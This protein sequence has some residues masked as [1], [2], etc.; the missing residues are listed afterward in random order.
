MFTKH[1]YILAFIGMF[2]LLIISKHNF[3]N[4]L[5]NSINCE[6]NIFFRDPNGSNPPSSHSDNGTP[7]WDTYDAIN[8]IYLELGTYIYTNSAN[9]SIWAHILFCITVHGSRLDYFNSQYLSL[10]FTYPLRILFSDTQR[11]LC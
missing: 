5:Y 11:V 1:H 3:L 7:F 4:F 10:I 2:M 9:K 8:Q 6:L